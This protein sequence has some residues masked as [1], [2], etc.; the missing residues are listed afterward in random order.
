M[1]PGDHAERA[2]ENAIDQE[3]CLN[4]V[5]NERSRTRALCK[6]YI[7]AAHDLG[8]A[9]QKV[10]V[11]TK[12]SLDEMADIYVLLAPTLFASETTSKNDEA[13]NVAVSVLSRAFPCSEAKR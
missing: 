9:Q 4:R 1:T 5:S 13:I 10:C 8:R 12:V 7:Q 2:E 6:G 11:V 3:L